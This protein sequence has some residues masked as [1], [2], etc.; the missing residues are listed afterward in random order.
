MTMLNDIIQLTIVVTAVTVIFATMA[1]L[2]I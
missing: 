1:G 2:I